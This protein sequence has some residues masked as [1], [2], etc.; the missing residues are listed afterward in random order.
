MGLYE[1]ARDWN[2]MTVMMEAFFS[3]VGSE[4]YSACERKLDSLFETEDKTME[5][6]VRNQCGTILL[7]LVKS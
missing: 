3:I 6:Q 4:T 5:L 2:G 1:S 7:L